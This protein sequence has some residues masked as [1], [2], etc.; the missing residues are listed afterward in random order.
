MHCSRTNVVHVREKKTFLSQ[1]QS[2]CPMNAKGIKP[3]V[4]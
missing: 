2:T 4:T 1:I 3:E